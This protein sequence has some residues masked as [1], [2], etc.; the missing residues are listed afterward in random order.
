M[1]IELLEPPGDAVEGGQAGDVVDDKHPDSSAVVGI[2]DSPEALLAGGVL[3]LGLDLLAV[4]LHALDLE[5]HTNGDDEI[6]SA[7]SSGSSSCFENSSS[8]CTSS[9]SPSPS[10]L[11]SFDACSS[12]FSVGKKKGFSGKEEVK[13]VG[14]FFGF[15]LTWEVMDIKWGAIF[16]NFYGFIFSL[17]YVIE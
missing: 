13:E 11:S 15:R 10:F 7:T 6:S 1:C 3:D 16:G 8:S 9:S 2:G 4:D 17:R 12:F 14:G 5:L